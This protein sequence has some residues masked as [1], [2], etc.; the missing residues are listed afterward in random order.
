[1]AL[2]TTLAKAMATANHP[3]NILGTELPKLPQNKLYRN[4]RI[5]FPDITVFIKIKKCRVPY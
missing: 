2:A 3:V 4:G 1:M 5:H